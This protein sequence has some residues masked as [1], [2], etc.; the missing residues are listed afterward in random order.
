MKIL[1]IYFQ[2]A[3]PIW[4]DFTDSIYYWHLFPLGIWCANLKNNLKCY[5]LYI[6]PSG[7]NPDFQVIFMVVAQEGQLFC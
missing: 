1:N 5:L 2:S 4:T 7:H 6:V 3:L